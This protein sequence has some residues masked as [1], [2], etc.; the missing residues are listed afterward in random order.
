MRT[1]SPDVRRQA[2]CQSYLYII[3]R[4]EV[5]DEL[6]TSKNTDL[7]RFFISKPKHE[8]RLEKEALRGKTLCASLGQM[9]KNAYYRILM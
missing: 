8:G 7:T 1:F 3:E 6:I 9:R 2:L 4:I 5:T